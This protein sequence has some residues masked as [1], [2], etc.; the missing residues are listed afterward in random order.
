MKPR[1]AAA[2][3]L[4]GCSIAARSLAVAGT[5]STSQ[6]NAR[7]PSSNLETRKE[8]F[9]KCSQRQIEVYYRGV[10]KQ[11]REKMTVE[12]GASWAVKECAKYIT[13]EERDCAAHAKYGYQ[14]GDPFRCE[15]PD[16]SAN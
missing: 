11:E 13:K 7:N 3:A 16:N 12:G 9:R 2:L 4:L 10:P 8:R 1:H 15:V 6:P 14:I 5:V